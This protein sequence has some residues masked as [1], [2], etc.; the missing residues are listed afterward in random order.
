MMA[1]AVPDSTPPMDPTAASLPAPPWPPK[2]VTVDATGPSA[3]DMGDLFTQ[4][5]GLR[6]Q[7]GA[8]KAVEN[9]PD[10]GDDDDRSS[11]QTTD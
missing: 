10:R 1:Y 5:S 2:K 11:A 8:V 3:F 9:E 4:I 7:M 6:S